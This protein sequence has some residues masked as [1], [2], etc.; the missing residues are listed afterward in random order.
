MS[1]KLGGAAVTSGVAIAVRH[2]QV[3][4]VNGPHPAVKHDK[5]MFHEDGGP[6]P[7]LK[8]GQKAICDW[9]YTGGGPK[10]A[11][12]ND[13][14]SDELKEFKKRVRARH[15]SFNSLIKAFNILDTRFRHSVCKHKACFEAVCVLVQYDMDTGRPIMEVV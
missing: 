14:D 12:R 10:C 4:L 9:L 11:I 7:K 2:P 5:T 8:N 1:K 13:F 3:V 6:G 15:E